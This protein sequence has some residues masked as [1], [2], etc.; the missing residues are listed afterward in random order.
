MLKGD[1]K[2]CLEHLRSLK[3]WEHFEYADVI[4]E[5]V[6]R[7]AKTECLRCYLMSSSKHFLND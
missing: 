5:K 6:E 4:K 3:C 2:A 7:R 1:W